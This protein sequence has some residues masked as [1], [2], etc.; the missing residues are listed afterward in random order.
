MLAQTL[1]FA[2]SL[3]PVLVSAGMYPASGPVKML[4][5]ATFKKVLKDEVRE[6]LHL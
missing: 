2:L 5:G 4:T 3:T 6:L 1:L